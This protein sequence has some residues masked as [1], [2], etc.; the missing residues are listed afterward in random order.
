MFRLDY[1]AVGVHPEHHV[2]ANGANANALHSFTIVL[3]MTA[4]VVGRD[5]CDVNVGSV[6][7][8]NPFGHAAAVSALAD[9]PTEQSTS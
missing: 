8:P 1:G 5:F 3:S 4:V 9:R 6:F 7:A 2:E